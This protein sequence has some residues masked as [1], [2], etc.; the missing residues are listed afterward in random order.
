MAELEQ[1]IAFHCG[2]NELKSK[3]R[4]RPNSSYELVDWVFEHTELDSDN[5]PIIWNATH[6]HQ[7]TSSLDYLRVNAVIR[8]NNV[9]LLRYIRQRCEH[10]GYNFDK[11]FD[12]INMISSNFY[13]YS[14]Y[15][16]MIAM[17][18]FWLNEYPWMINLNVKNHLFNFDN[19]CRLK[20]HDAL[21]LMEYIWYQLQ[22][23][24]M[25]FECYIHT[26]TMMFSMGYRRLLEWFMSKYDELNIPFE[27]SPLVID[28]ICEKNN[29]D[30]LQWLWD[31]RYKIDF[32]YDVGAF[33]ISCTYRDMKIFRWWIE[34]YD[35]DGLQLKYT[36]DGITNAFGNAN[37]DLL[38]YMLTRSDLEFKFNGID[39]MISDYLVYQNQHVDP[40]GRMTDRITS[41]KWYF[42]HCDILEIKYTGLFI[43]NCCTHDDTR[44]LEYFFEKISEGFEFKYNLRYLYRYHVNALK[45]IKEHLELFDPKTQ[46][47]IL[48]TEGWNSKN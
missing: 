43:D 17:Y 24:S 7:L 35:I 38:D 48:H 44:L 37:I 12:A 29:I 32:N 27:Y 22:K 16:R 47:L 18:E 19:I 14:E 13:E 31:L 26:I 41:V 10:F 30:L 2:D 39:Y 42:D 1:L 11:T 46:D 20:E 9:E 3:Y 34:R 6:T 25:S 28:Q 4:P 45:V 21:K 33:D 23:Y 15:D 40:I 5:K 8:D 36:S